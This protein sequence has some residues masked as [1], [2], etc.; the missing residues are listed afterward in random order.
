MDCPKVKPPVFFR[1]MLFLI[2]SS[3]IVLLFPLD[4]QAQSPPISLPPGFLQE[5]VI[6]GLDVPTSFDI[7][8]DGRIFITEKSGV[9]RVFDGE[10]LQ[11]EPF[12]D[13]R[14]EV[15]SIADRGLM[16]VAVH[17]QFPDVPYVYLSYV[18]EPV[19]AGG[20]SDDGARVSRVLRLSANNGNPNV[21]APGTGLVIV[22]ANSTFDHI[23][24]PHQ[25]NKSPFSCQVDGGDYIVDCLPAEGTAHVIGMVRFGPDGALYV[26]NGDGTQ[27][28]YANGRA[29]D[30]NS[31]AGKILRVNPV[32][33]QGY[34]SNPFYDGNPSSNRSKVYVMGM[35]NPFRFT[36]NPFTNELFVADVGN[37]VWE[38]INKGGPGANFGW[39]CF[40]GP[41]RSAE[42]DI[43]QPLFDGAQP[44]TSA[45]YLY[46]HENGLGAAI[47][48]DFYT[49]RLFP[50]AY[51]GG[52]FFADFNASL[53]QFLSLLGGERVRTFAS[54]ALGVVQLSA[55]EGNLYVLYIRHGTLSRIRYVGQNAP[56]VARFGASATHG[57]EP[58]RVDFDGSQSYDPNQ[59]VLT[60]NWDLGTGATSTDMNPT[61][62]Y[63][64]T[65]E[66]DVKLTV[67]DSNGASRSA[68]IRIAVGNDPPVAQILMPDPSARFNIGDEVA[69]LGWANDTE[70]G[71]LS[72]NSLH[73]ETIFHHR[74]H[75]HYNF[76]ESRGP[77]GKFIY[78]D[79]GDNTYL[80]L[81]LT[82]TDS[83]GL[84]SRTCADL[85]A[86]EVIYTIKSVPSGMPVLYA[87]SPYQ[88]PFKVIS[89]VNAERSISAGQ[90]PTDDSQFLIWSDGGPRRRTLIMN[91]TDTTLTALYSGQDGPIRQVNDES[92]IE[93]INPESAD[94]AQA[95]QPQFASVA[96]SAPV[97]TSARTAARS[98]G[99]Q[100]AAAALRGDG[101]ILREW[102]LDIA[103]ASV[104]NLRR[105]PDFPNK[106][107]GA[108]Y[109]ARFEA[110][111]SFGKDYGQR[112][113]GYLYPPVTGDY[114]FWMAA[115]DTGELWLSTDDNP[116][117][118]RWIAGTS[119]WTS[120][121]EWDR[122]P[123]QTSLFIPLEAGKRYYI[124]ALHKEADNKD[125]MSV[126]WLIPDGRFSVI[127][128]SFLSPYE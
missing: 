2:M 59:D 47:G 34:A 92:P 124:L 10:Q 64:E 22:G 88:T 89:Y 16:S 121:R 46:P 123:E 128:G 30:P 84:A 126:A 71:L 24:N 76:F 115:D 125:N 90:A 1:G 93:I 11:P 65:G 7:T 101:R 17:P 73:W 60:F 99:A 63:T 15:N 29:V 44:V 112:I 41:D 45:V 18:Y 39:P 78:A 43:C 13:L 35:R 55:Y 122:Y 117:N 110:P 74:D 87:G 9:V 72:G 79:H 85:K 66:Y 58:L 68:S 42:H 57:R 32:T 107:A 28:I 105:H 113:H 26:A 21:H 83:N 8:T 100:G 114:R 98:A 38:E 27:N 20:Y 69:F 37:D 4:S 118:V 95:D 50:A 81:C 94:T 53:I 106:P 111:L 103:G 3:F 56:P 40:E 86:R 120:S 82:A 54:G 109:L 108:E 31:L 80:E 96:F 91:E 6:T 97:A 102:W 33:G 62:T 61:H 52:Y 116:A 36:F 77:S 70:D 127:E 67:S 75:E 51:R 104:E 12:V 48:G 119:A 14:H 25:A 49:G 23:G 5:D 19:A